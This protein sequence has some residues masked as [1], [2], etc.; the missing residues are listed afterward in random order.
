MPDE[1]KSKWIMDIKTEDL[2]DDKKLVKMEPV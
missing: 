1:E 2:Q